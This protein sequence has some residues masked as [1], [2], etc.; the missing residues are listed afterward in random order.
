MSVTHKP[1]YVLHDLYVTADGAVIQGMH[2]ENGE[3]W[4]VLSDIVHSAHLTVN[5]TN[6]AKKLKVTDC[7]KRI[8]SLSTGCINYVWTVSPWGNSSSSH[9]C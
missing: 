2:I 4:Y 5:T 7:C 8:V 9:G 6:A 1:P 3:T